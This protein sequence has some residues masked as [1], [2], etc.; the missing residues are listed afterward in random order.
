[1]ISTWHPPARV[2]HERSTV[3]ASG[4]TLDP[5]TASRYARAGLANVAREYPNQPAHLL[6]GPE[7][8]VAP[9]E[10]HPIFHGS[11]DWHSAVH[12]HW[13]LVRLVRRVPDLPEA[14]AIGAWFD[15][16]LTDAAVAAEAAYLRRPERRAWER[17][18]GWAW[19][20]L[21]SAELAS[22]ARAAADDR[23]RPGDVGVHDAPGARDAARW[24]TTLAELTET[25]RGRCLDW[26]A[27]TT[28]PQRGGTHPNSA[29]ACTLLHDA[30]TVTGDAELL[31]AVTGAAARWYAA[32]VDYPAWIEPS[33]SDFLSPVLVQADLLRRVLPPATFPSR[34]HRLLPD[35]GPLLE[36]AVVSDRTDPQTVHLDGLNLSRAWC[37]LG[38]ADA[39]DADDPLR[40]VATVAA[41]RHAR[42]SLPAVLDGAYVGEHW[43]PT[44]AVHLLDVADRATT[45]DVL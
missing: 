1:M 38:I 26:L 21:L 16:R 41:G 10:L 18:Y 12:Q 11:Y 6:T 23:E 27:T 33:A 24:W 4:L 43:L 34:F 29:F 5:A 42:A 7:D 35:P 32:D 13:M 8:L 40:P 36:P 14:A 45:L 20:L 3:R 44:F 39:L 30:A 28:Y 9:S 17:P 15:H 37:W 2:R 22:W 25:V 31:E 19:L